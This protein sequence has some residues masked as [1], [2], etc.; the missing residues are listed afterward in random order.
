MQ[1]ALDLTRLPPPAQKILSPGAPPA[2]RQVAAR[3]VV[4]GL[5]PGDL[6]A[7]IAA[8]A[9]SDDEAI[10]TQAT[11]T[12]GNLP[13]PVLTGALAADLEPGVIDVLA[14]VSTGRDEVL[15]RLAAMPRVTGDTLAH[16]AAT[17]SEALTEAIAT[18]EARLLTEPLVIEKLYHNRHV[19]MSTVQRLIE[20]AHRNGVEVKGI[21]AFKE[22]GEMLQDE[23]IPAPDAEPDP[24]D[25]MF[26][27]ADEMARQLEENVLAPGDDLFED[28]SD[29]EEADPDSQVSPEMAG[30]TRM[31]SA[32]DDAKQ[33]AK[34]K[35][36]EEAGPL[37]ARLGD[38]SI[39]ERIRMATIG[40]GAARALLLRDTNKLVAGAAISSPMTQEQDVER[41]S[42][43]RTV[44]Q[45]VLRFIA[46]QGKWT[47]N[48]VIK[49]NLVANP[50]TPV[51]NAAKFV[52]H[53]REDELKRLEKNRD[54]SAPV[55]TLIKQQLQRKTKK[56]G[57]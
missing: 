12:L 27:E 55:R 7:V 42:K 3:G 5:K 24:I 49:F 30:T 41:I 50:R 9:E 36:E 48:H 17:G 38:M 18:N 2:L 40:P 26:L 57:K 56:P 25:L 22:Q 35:K 52:M 54:V 8:L 29:P 21:P 10:R 32:L 33:K 6:V 19:R 43:M 51:A 53:L 15:T 34:K 31:L 14:R 44:H 20:L 23:L 28:L 47:E 45:E 37:H 46:G 39:S 13:P 4:P 1:P 11:T 16:L